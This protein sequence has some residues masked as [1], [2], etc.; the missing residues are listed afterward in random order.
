M[1]RRRGRSTT[2]ANW[3]ACGLAPKAIART[4]GLRPAIV[5]DVVRKLAAERDA[6]DPDGGLV[7]C[8]INAGRSAGLTITGHP[9]GRRP[10]RP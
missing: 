5:A 8:W 10:R 6:A 4:L 9:N 3:R 2:S 7:D 1:G